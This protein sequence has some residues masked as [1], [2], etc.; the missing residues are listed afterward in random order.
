M[1]AVLPIKNLPIPPMLLE[2]IREGLWEKIPL[3]NLRAIAPFLQEPLEL[4]ENLEEIRSAADNPGLLGSPVLGIRSSQRSG[5]AVRLPLL[6]YDHCLFIAVNKFPGDDIAIVL[7]YRGNHSNPRVVA[8]D[9]SSGS[10]CEWR[11]IANNFA[12]FVRQLTQDR[13]D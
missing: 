12:A 6:D 13:Q 2:L 1:E 4:L 9:F 11:V 3:D 10:H 5:K 8:S 7:D